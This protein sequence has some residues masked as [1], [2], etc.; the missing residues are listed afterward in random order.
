[1]EYQ[2]NIRKILDALIA[3]WYVIPITALI[4]LCGGIILSDTDAPDVYSATTTIYSS[5]YVS[6][7][8][9]VEVRNAIQ[10]YSDIIRSKR[11]AERASSIIAREIPPEQIIGMISTSNPVNSAIFVIR[12]VST[13]PATAVIVVNAVAAAFIQEI[14]HVTSVD[15][16]RVLDTANN[17]QL[18]SSGSQSSLQ[19]RFI[20]TAIGALLSALIIAFLAAVDKRAAFPHE[21]TLNGAIE[22]IGAI[23]EKKT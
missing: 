9:S 7:R 4:F 21:V 1:M 18:F 5:S 8:D 19:T 14:E 3:K 22:L 6:Y 20:A 15:G 23:P 16:V 10:F 2:I 17:A 12:A 11:V 13:E